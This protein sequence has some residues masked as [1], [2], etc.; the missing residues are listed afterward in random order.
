[1]RNQS[2]NPCRPTL[3]Y[4]H[5]FRVSEVVAL[6]VRP[7]RPEPGPG[8]REPSEERSAEHAPLRGPNCVCCG[9]FSVISPVPTSSQLG[10]LCPTYGALWR[11]NQNTAEIVGVPG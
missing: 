3:M 5:S 8:A 7:D 11:R 1:M 9:S 6:R 4:R 2:S 10:A